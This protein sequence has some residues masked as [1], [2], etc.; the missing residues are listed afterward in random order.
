MCI[1]V[2]S[3]SGEKADSVA[4]FES[5]AVHLDASS[6]A[7]PAMPAIIWACDT[8]GACTQL[9]S[10]WTAFTG[11]RT[12]DC[13]GW[14]F[15]EAIH[16]DDRPAITQAFQNAKTAGSNY[17]VE[18]RLRHISGG[19]RWVLDTATP[20]L[21]ASGVFAGFVG[22]I[23]DNEARKQAEQKLLEREREL[24]L[25]TDTVPVLIAHVN[26]AE[27][28]VFANSTYYE[29]YGVDPEQII[30][31][32]IAELLGPERYASRKPFIDAALNGERVSYDSEVQLKDGS[33]RTVETVYVPNI[34]SSGNVDGFIAI[35]SDISER[36]RSQE[37]LDLVMRE[38]KHHMRNLLG[39]V[40]GLSSQTFRKDRPLRDAM[41]AFHGR[42]QALAAASDAITPQNVSTADIEDIVRNVVAPYRDKDA[43]P[44]L[45]QGTSVKLSTTV[46]TSLA[47][48]LHELC[49][50]ALKYGALSVPE[51]RVMLKWTSD[52]EGFVL[53]WAEQGGPA[54]VPAA[55]VGFGSTLLKT[56][57]SAQ[58]GSRTDLQ[59]DPAGVRCRIV[60]RRSSLPDLTR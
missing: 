42:L 51:G 9:G 4:Q 55:R 45:I 5:G 24:R 25:V 29:W 52:A 17:Q 49:T 21:D 16:H 47:M 19:Y 57:L 53:D 8:A 59:F 41:D 26:K 31:K 13:L 46:A 48:A 15:E 32:S 2:P 35:V 33:T 58:P 30:G 39:L 23:V 20:E 40:Q 3:V 6:L 28:Y 11:L 44:F 22:A 7:R 50:N 37:H 34:C 60:L 10:A 54:V 12:E 43:D 38:L 14:G 1:V 36:R 56:A 27:R 18:Y